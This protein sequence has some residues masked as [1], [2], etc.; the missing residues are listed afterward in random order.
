MDF[1][2]IEYIYRKTGEKLI[3]KVPGEKYLK[4]LYYNP[5]GE[6]ALNLV[7]KRKFLTW[8]YGKEMD[9]KSSV[10][11]IKSLIES[12]GINMAESKK[13]ID[14]FNSFNEFFIRELKS[15]A[16]EIDMNENTLVSPA[17][18]RI[19]VYE[20]LSEVSKFF[21]KGDEFTLQEFFKDD[22]LAEKYK[23]GVFMIIR[24][25]PVDYHRYHFPADGFINKSRLIEGYY[26]S[27]SPHAIKKN[28]RI[29]C[30]NKREYS[31]LKT[32]KFGD[33]I[34][35]EIAAT[36]VGGIIQS[37]TPD[38]FIK[39]GDEKGYFYFGGSTVIM[40]FEKGKVAVDKDLILNSQNGIETKV[41]MGEKI[42]VS[43]I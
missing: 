25:A 24:L 4:F 12:A 38:T 16:R 26:Y 1:K 3:E 33:I 27:V 5:F 6:L 2:P 40:I 23:D 31:T 10:S 13:N 30:E 29:Y 36:M 9:K 39:K 18:G 32:E 19:F 37:Y 15:G 41:Y 20:N 7:I 35:S 22:F 14:E 28:F 17:D 42:G 43:V 11:K 34:I 8:Y 21:L